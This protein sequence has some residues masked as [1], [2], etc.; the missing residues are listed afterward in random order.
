[1]LVLALVRQLNKQDKAPT[2][3]I[4]GRGFFLCY[5]SPR[6]KRSRKEAEIIN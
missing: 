3:L 4:G 2:S 1:M 5:A 6:K